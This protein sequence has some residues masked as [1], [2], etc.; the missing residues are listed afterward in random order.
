MLTSFYAGS[1]STLEK[2]AHLPTSFVF[3]SKN[4]YR[5]LLK[6]SSSPPI[7]PR[8]W[9]PFLRPALDLVEHWALVRDSQPENFKSDLSWLITLKAIKVCDSLRNWGYIP[10]DRCASCPH[11]ETIDHWFL[12]CSRVKLV[13]AF[14][15]PFLSALLTPPA[16]LVPNC[17][18]VFFFRFPP[19][20]SR[21]CAIVIYLIKSILT[22]SGNFIIRQPFT[23]APSL[24]ML[25]FS[26]SFKML[27]IESSWI[28]FVSL[29]R[30]F[31][32][33]RCTRH[34]VW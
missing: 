6:E 28:I 23:M 18:S 33:F 9:S 20:V 13:W 3:T 14:F 29:L 11:R 25:L 12:N 22:V 1:L 17:V 19:C 31:R 26:T 24:I 4:V 32:P 5:K 21:N 15:V 10:S 34:F 16:S 30:G 8:F 27:P 2:L 7:L